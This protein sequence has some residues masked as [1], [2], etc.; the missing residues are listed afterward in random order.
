MFWIL[1][2]APFTV[3]LLLGALTP[4]RVALL[5]LPPLAIGLVYWVGVGWTGTDYDMGKAGLVLFT[6]I[7]ALIFVSLWVVGSLVGRL[8][9]LGFERPAGSRPARS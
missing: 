5:A 4:I 7:F 9:R 8:V 2:A 6:G 1:V 3:G